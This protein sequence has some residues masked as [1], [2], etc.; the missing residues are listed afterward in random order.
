[1][2][3]TYWQLAM[4]RVAVRVNGKSALNIMVNLIGTT[5]RAKIAIRES[6]L[7]GLSI[8][9]ECSFQWHITYFEDCVN[10]SQSLFEGQ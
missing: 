8:A 5:N 7:I 3:I 9:I 2:A 4:E 10:Y 1:M 6:P